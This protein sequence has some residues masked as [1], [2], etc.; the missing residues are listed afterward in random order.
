MRK[1]IVIGMLINGLGG[2][3]VF[4]IIP[5]LLGATNKV[6]MGAVLGELFFIPLCGIIGGLMGQR[7]FRWHQHGM[8]RG[9]VVLYAGLLGAALWVATLL[10][11]I[12]IY[13]SDE[14]R[15]IV[16]FGVWMWRFSTV[17]WAFIIG[18]LCGI[19]IAYAVKI[20]RKM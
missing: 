4:A 20:V 7:S 11:S 18:P 2:P 10:I 13:F 3:L 6:I 9:H 16:S 1:A 17:L 5:V 8:S 12:G 19:W 14:T 15:T